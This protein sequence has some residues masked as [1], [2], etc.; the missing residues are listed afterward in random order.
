MVP[1][2]FEDLAYPEVVGALVLFAGDNSVDVGD[3][4][5]V[6]GAPL[7]RLSKELPGEWG[8]AYTGRLAG[9]V[10]AVRHTI[11]GKEVQ[12]E[13]LL[14]SP[15]RSVASPL[16]FMLRGQHTARSIYDLRLDDSIAALD[17]GFQ[18]G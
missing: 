9:L 17:E 16:N 12:T 7:R 3:L 5:E 2:L 18:L 11:T 8:D 4:I 14:T 6:R 13:L 10:R 15:M 1:R